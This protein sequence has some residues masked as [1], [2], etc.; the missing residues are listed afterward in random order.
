LEPVR[1]TCAAALSH[2]VA[3]LPCGETIPP[4]LDEGL[5]ARAIAESATRSLASGRSEP[6]AY[7][8]SRTCRRIPDNDRFSLTLFG[9]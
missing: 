4:S 2:F 7:P 8:A 6:I 5:R 1:P 3:A 9:A